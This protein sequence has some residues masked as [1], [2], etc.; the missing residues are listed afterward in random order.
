KTLLIELDRSRHHSAIVVDDGTPDRQL[1][2]LL[3]QVAL[4]PRVKLLVNSHNLG[5]VGAVNRALGH[6]TD[7]DVILLNADTIVPQGFIDRLASAARSSPG[8]GTVTPLSNNGEF[9]SFPVPYTANRLGSPA[10]VAEIDKIAAR[11]NSGA[12]VDMP[13]G[14]GFCLYITRTCLN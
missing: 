3:R 4:H 5:F 12:V 2:R 11:V 6:I 14:I 13:S 8:I 7:G 1:A 10:E 9:T